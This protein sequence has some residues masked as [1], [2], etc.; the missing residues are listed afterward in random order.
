MTSLEIPGTTV[1][2][3]DVRF[4][5]ENGFLHL[6]GV[7]SANELAGLRAFEE[8]V[9]A[10]AQAGPIP[11]SKY[12]YATD[13]ETGTR[14]MYR[15]N[16]AQAFG[17]AFLN[18]YGSPTHFRI[19]EAIFGP[20]FIPF[21][22]AVVVKRPGYG[23]SIPW[24]RDPSGW[25]TTPG[26]NLGVYFDDA[27]PENG[28]LYVVPGS[29][30]VTDLDLQHLIEEHGFHIPGS[31]PVAAKAGDII[32]H[33][34]HVLHGS[35]V[36]RAQSIRR[37]MYCNFHT[38][39]EQLSKGGKYTPGWVRFFVRSGLHALSTRAASPVGQGETPYEWKLSLEYQCTLE[40]DQYVEMELED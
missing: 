38:I 28:M 12:R 32:V 20:D 9:S 2:A 14:V 1:S 4:F 3:E 26:I 37:V 31:I 21:G 33:N 19:A 34:E 36:V 25:R 23:P 5:H 39:E 6:K 10:A 22:S 24:H 17:G 13:P 40:P 16:A 7:V 30:R 27:T 18:L 35:R 11:S 29:H 15:I 8:S